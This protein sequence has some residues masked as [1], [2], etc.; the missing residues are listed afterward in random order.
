MKWQIQQ[1]DPVQELS[2]QVQELVSAKTVMA[3]ELAVLLSKMAL[4]PL[5]YAE[6]TPPTLPWI[7]TRKGTKKS[8][9][10]Y[11][12]SL[13]F[14]HLLVLSNSMRKGLSLP[15]FRVHN[16]KRLSFFTFVRVFMYIYY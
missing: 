16:Q 9:T 13:S 3:P 12:P 15:L 1:E 2:P 7:R 11:P 4:I 10:V 14:E 5:Q 8:L 6:Q